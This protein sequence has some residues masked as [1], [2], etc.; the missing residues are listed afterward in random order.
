MDIP[1]MLYAGLNRLG[2]KTS[3]LENSSSDTATSR[4]PNVKPVVSLLLLPL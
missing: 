4:T 2:G 3:G 1:C